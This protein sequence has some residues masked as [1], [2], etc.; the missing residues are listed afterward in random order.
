MNDKQMLDRLLET[1]RPGQ[2]LGS[3]EEEAIKRRAEQSSCPQ[4]I[5]DLYYG[6]K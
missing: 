5:K 6:A 4:Q 1:K 3:M 2:S